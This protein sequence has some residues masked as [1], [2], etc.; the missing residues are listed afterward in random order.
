MEL[1]GDE[2]LAFIKSSRKDKEPLLEN[3]D[4]F[5]GNIARRDGDGGLL[6]AGGQ[7]CMRWIFSPEAKDLIS[8]HMTCNIGIEVFAP[9]VLSNERYMPAS[10]MPLGLH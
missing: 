2:Y 7:Q 6:E 4:L 1:L 3:V 5:I 8:E 9:K 10:A